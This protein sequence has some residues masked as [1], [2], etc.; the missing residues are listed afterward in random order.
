MKVENIKLALV[1]GLGVW[2]A[3][4]AVSLVLAP[5]ET[6]NSPFFESLKSIALAVIASAFIVMYLKKVKQSTALEGLIIGAIWAIITVALDYVLYA[7]GLFGDLTFAEYCN[8]VASSYVM[9]PAL[10][11][12]IMGTLKKA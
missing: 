10:G 4:V 8:D 3:L 2:V 6:T 12:I 5:V 1:Y 9:I 7:F 11:A